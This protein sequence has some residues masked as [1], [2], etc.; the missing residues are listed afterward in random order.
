MAAPVLNP[1]RLLVADSLPSPCYIIDEARLENNLRLLAGV[2][3]R[4]GCHILLAQKAYACPATY[5]LIGQYLQGTAASGLF[6]ARL[7]K[8]EMGGEVHVFAAAYREDEFAELLQYADHIIFNSGNQ[9]LKFGPQAK[10]AG[11]SCGL[12]VNPEFSTQDHAIYDPCAPGSR[13]RY[14]H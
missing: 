11:K 6:E 10:A 3:R 5:P 2:K 9:L 7:G 4:T 8:E 13:G 1:A 12:R 14:R